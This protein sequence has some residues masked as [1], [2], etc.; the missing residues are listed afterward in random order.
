VVLVEDEEPVRL[1]VERA[2]V[3][4]GIVV[5][6]FDDYP[7]ADTVLAAAPDL[8]V[9]D[10]LLPSGDGFELARA[11]RAARDVPVVFLTARDASRRRPR[12]STARPAR[13]RPSSA[14]S[15]SIPTNP[16]TASASPSLVASSSNITASSPATLPPPE[17]ASPSGSR[18][19]PVEG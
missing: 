11:L 18:T 15:D 17:P 5:T 16:D 13:Q 8:A 10:V 9:L 7:G 14:S 4:E 12:Q 19:S 3:R 2:L 1:A 6:G